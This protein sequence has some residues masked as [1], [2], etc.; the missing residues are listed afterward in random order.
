M[1]RSLWYF[2]HNGRLG[3][4]VSVSQLRELAA[5]GELLPSDRVRKEDMERWV[6]ARVVKG[7]FLAMD[8]PPMAE[9]EPTAEPVTDT[10]F[11]FFGVGPAAAPDPSKEFHP[12]FDFFGGLPPPPAK[13]VP[14]PAEVELQ[15]V[16]PP[17]IRKSPPGRKSKPDL[18]TP[19]L[20]AVD[21]PVAEAI[22]YAH[23]Q[24]DV[25][26]AMPASDIRKTSPP[27]TAELTG[28][29]VEMT[30]EGTARLT[31]AV[32]DL[33]VAGSWLVAKAATSDGS[34]S[35]NYLRLRQLSAVTLR[36]RADAGFVLSF[37]AGVQTVAMRIEG[38]ATVARAFLRRV[39]EAVSG[40]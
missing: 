30:P 12:A 8:E 25:P 37:H 24:A 14:P 38:D 23:F 39:L 19:D 27:I 28:P 32:S 10:V 22:P 1:S 4:P 36:D 17:P 40:K 16:P 9:P 2:D 7:L 26:M 21:V 18:P 33:S 6:K 3:G 15:P 5:N 31:G 29:E 20:G 13:T 35:E 34:V 11:D